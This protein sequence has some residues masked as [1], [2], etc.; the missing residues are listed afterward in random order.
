MDLLFTVTGH[1]HRPFRT[2]F[3]SI[4]VPGTLSLANIQSRF[5]TAESFNP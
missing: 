2:E 1:F 4:T 5:A 3:R